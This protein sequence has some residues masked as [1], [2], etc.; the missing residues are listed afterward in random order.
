MR[1][2]SVLVARL[3]TSLA[4]FGL[5]A[6]VIPIGG[7]EV[8]DLRVTWSFAEG[9]G[10]ASQRCADV[11][12]DNVTIQLIEKGKEGQG[13]K[14]FG[15]TAECIAGSMV[16]PLVSAG[17]Y[18]LTATGEGEVAVFDNEEGITVEVKPNEETAV[19]APLVLAN[20]EVV[21]RVEFQYTFAG[22]AAC[23]AA[24]VATINAQIIDENGT[25]IAGS[26]TD[27]IVGL[28]VIEGVRV[29]EH[30]LQVEAVDGDGN[31]RFFKSITVR[32]LQAGK[33]LRPDP[34]DLDAALVDIVV[35]FDFEDQDSCAAAG[36]ANVDVQLID[37]LGVVAGQ[38]VNCVDGKATF[39]AMPMDINDD[40]TIDALD[41][42]TIRLD[43]ID[44]NGEVLFSRSQDEV[45]F[46][47]DAP[48]VSVTLDAVSSTVLIRF[49][50]PGGLSCAELGQPN[51]DIQIVD[52]AGN[53]T[54]TNV[55][56]IAGDSGP[57]IAAP[58]RSSV[59]IDAIVGDDVVF[60]GED[61][62]VALDAGNNFEEIPLVAVRSTLEVSWDFLLVEPPVA[63]TTTNSCIEADIDT[64][65]VRVFRA[66]S[67]ELAQ[68]VDC[69]EGRVEMPGIGIGNVRV[70]LE[71]IRLQEGDAPF[72]VDGNVTVAG[73]RTQADFTLDPALVFVLIAWAGDCGVANTATVDVRVDVS[74]FSSG[75]NLPCAQGSQKLVLPRGSELSLITINLRGVDGQGV[76]DQGADID[77]LADVA[78]VPGINNFRFAGPR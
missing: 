26:N 74:G 66:G 50:F 63:P 76:P 2:C 57:L 44:G 77:I 30:T 46:S 18:T 37:D 32:A 39:P 23:S 16:I 65:I 5:A 67:L 19:D 1:F 43:A 12:V 51:I 61:D 64:V 4:T 11:G 54:G 68:A 53:A 34:I 59:F 22:Q 52:S 3:A 33:T 13:G 7:A 62:N 38:N 28:A 49:T 73:N 48:E 6:C 8:G 56:C 47:P 41:V 9:T 71:G 25:A 72:F 24:D 69:N 40:G 45:A 78:V 20:G 70:E 21:S 31:I 29:G 36:V 17:T 42:Y 75:I 60:H 58:G 35:N 55:P 15:Q 14:A 27:C 10:N